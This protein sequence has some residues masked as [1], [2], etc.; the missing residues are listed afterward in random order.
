MKEKT[1]WPDWIDDRLPQ[2][3]DGDKDGNILIYNPDVGQLFENYKS[4]I[5]GCRI[6]EAVSYIISYLHY[7]IVRDGQSWTEMTAS[8]GRTYSD[9]IASPVECESRKKEQVEM[10]NEIEYE[11]AKCQEEFIGN[12]GVCPLCGYGKET[13]PWIP[14]DTPNTWGMYELTYEIEGD[15]HYSVG[16]MIFDEDK[17]EWE[18]PIGINEKIIAHKAWVFSPPYVPPERELL[19]PFCDSMNCSMKYEGEWFHC[20]MCS[21]CLKEN[22]KGIFEIYEK[23]NGDKK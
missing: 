10:P 4:I 15:E 9:F 7:T 19:C 14:G 13:N 6:K 12:D 1:I 23:L 17:Q 11:C 3:E 20:R 18:K 22:K 5:S 8:G 21:A 16:A 2:K